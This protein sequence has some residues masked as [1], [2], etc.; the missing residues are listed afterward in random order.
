M[1]ILIQ[2]TDFTILKLNT[3][4][5]YR[6]TGMRLV[7]EEYWYGNTGIGILIF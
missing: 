6:N 7:V 1:G 4:Y 5:W 3:E 2:N